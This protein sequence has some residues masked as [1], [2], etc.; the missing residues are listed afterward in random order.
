MEYVE[1]G[2]LRLI[3]IISPSSEIKIMHSLFCWIPYSLKNSLKKF[4]NFLSI[5]WTGWEPAHQ[6]QWISV[7]V[8]YSSRF[9][10]GAPEFVL[11]ISPSFRLEIMHSFF[12][13]ITYSSRNI[14]SNFQIFFSTVSTSWELV[15]PDQCASLYGALILV[16][17]EPKS[18]LVRA[19]KLQIS[20]RHG[21]GPV[22]GYFVGFLQPTLSPFGFLV[23]KQRD[24]CGQLLTS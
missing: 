3:S 17:L 2:A 24:K 6:A 5:E 19:H 9:K 12:F 1:F 21:L 18:Y 8:H 13:W 15:Q 22:V 4:E 20:P 23:L 10:F 11:V 16:I 14:L 7:Q